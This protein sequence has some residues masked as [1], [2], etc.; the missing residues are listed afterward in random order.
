MKGIFSLSITNLLTSLILLLLIQPASAATVLTETIVNS[1]DYFNGFESLP[2]TITQ[3]NLHTEDN[4]TVRQIDGDA[5]DISTNHGQL[6]VGGSGR[7]WYPNGGDN[8]YTSITLADG[9]LFGDVSLLAGTGNGLTHIFYHYSLLNN[10]SVVLSG[11]LEISGTGYNEFSFIGGGFDEILLMVTSNINSSFGLG[12]LNALDVD[13]I[14]VS[15]EASPHMVPIPA[16]I[17]LLSSALL[18]L[19]SLSRRKYL[20]SSI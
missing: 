19:V 14:A 17:W 13:S 6:L 11:S 1:P 16:S 7:S 2:I 15:L 5:N 4:I 9:N 12:D 8:G 3:G 10:E 18:G 20:S